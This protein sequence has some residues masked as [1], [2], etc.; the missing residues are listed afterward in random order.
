MTQ[1]KQALAQWAH[2]LDD[3]N[4]GET[5]EQETQDLPPEPTTAPSTQ[6]RH[7]SL[8]CAEV[9]ERASAQVPL[10][11][12]DRYE[13]IRGNRGSFAIANALN[14]SD[15][16]ADFDAHIDAAIRMSMAG[17]HQYGRLR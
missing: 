9:T 17:R 1:I 5:M 10:S 11:D 15:R 2:A 3:A 14:H 16:D 13:W 8:L 7:V 12:A 6:R 4:L